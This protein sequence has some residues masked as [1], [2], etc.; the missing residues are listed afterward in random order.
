[1][2]ARRATH[3]DRIS[4]GVAGQGMRSLSGRVERENGRRNA[5]AQIAGRRESDSV[6][7]LYAGA[8]HAGRREP[9]VHE[10]AVA[11]IAG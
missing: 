8:I 1:M 9:Q 10:R 5:L 11:G 6:I 7:D 4:A 3:D 2:V